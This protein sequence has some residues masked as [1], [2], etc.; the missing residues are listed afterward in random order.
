MDLK[1]LRSFVVLAEELHFGRAAHR[2]GLTQSALSQQLQKLET[3]LEVQLLVRTSREVALTE[4]GTEFLEPALGALA[5][6]NRAY[7]SVADIKAGRAGRLRLGSLSAGMNGILAP[8]L[9][10]YRVRMPTSIIEVHGSDSRSQERSLVAWELDAVVVR[11]LL[12]HSVIATIPLTEEKLVAFLPEGHP[13]ADRPGVWLEELK[14]EHFVFW[15][16]QRMTSFHDSV[17]KVCRAHGFEPSIQAYGDT[18]EAHLTLVAAGGVISLQS[19]MNTSIDRR[20]VRM[21]P[22]LDED[23]RFNLWLAY[24]ATKKT[25]ALNAFLACVQEVLHHAPVPPVTA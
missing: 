23:V 25:P 21:V 19:D 2:L 16:R 24:L 20:G 12:D 17:L 5:A 7:D 14:D 10:R 15:Q 6:A 1:H 11:G 3:V 18:L 9:E 13:L 8:I 22:V 4:A